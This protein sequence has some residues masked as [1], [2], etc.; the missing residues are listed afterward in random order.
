[1]KKL[2]IICLAMSMFTCT[3]MDH[4]PFSDPFKP[5]NDRDPELEPY[6]PA[7]IVINSDDAPSSGSYKSEWQV[8]RLN[9]STPIWTGVISRECN[10]TTIALDTSYPLGNVP[11]GN[12]QISYSR[13]APCGTYAIGT[14][15]VTII[16]GNNSCTFNISTTSSSNPAYAGFSMS[17]PTLTGC[18]VSCPY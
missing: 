11:P 6:C 16:A 15:Q 10:T 14:S 8:L 7:Y 1:M 12:Y 18:F 13:V 4:S 3:K 17:N 9:S 5:A 2:I